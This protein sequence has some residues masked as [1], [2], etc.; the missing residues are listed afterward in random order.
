MRGTLRR[1]A[2]IADKEVRHLQRDP[3]SLALAL[4]MPLVM[5]V[6]FGYGVSFDLDH[7]PLRIVDED[8]SASSRE[9]SRRVF[10]NGEFVG[11]ETPPEGKPFAALV[12]GEVAAV[13]VIHRGF[14][15]ELMR[16]ETPHLQVLI[17]GA[18][19]T[20]A[21][22]L[23]TKVEQTLGFLVGSMRTPPGMVR[24]PPV[25]A[26]TWTRFNPESRSV[27]YLLPGI[28]AFVLA[29]VAVLLTS[30]TIAREWERGSMA[31]LFA[32]PVRRVDI[33]LGKLLPYI[34]L[35]G[36]AVLLVIAAGMAI[37]DVPFRGS[38]LALFVLS[39]LFLIG[40]LGQGLLIS[41]ITRNQMVATQVATLSS[42]LPALLLSGFMFPIANMPTA[43]R[44]L[45]TIIP[46]R[47]YVEGL[48][49]VLLRGNGLGD[50]A[51]EAF[52]MGVFAVA[53]ISLST[54]RFKRSIA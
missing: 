44:G 21:S 30:L 53:V 52:A 40:M 24:E 15:R 54:L 6:L 33:V 4:V 8:G 34:V 18:D 37:F 11:T 12:S 48:R 41:V 45:T 43:L 22:Q 28:A 26:R 25:E 29:M 16:G 27:V 38:A 13:L 20:T 1:I 32:T 51:G 47:Y 39:L 46:A 49:G 50:V 3:L 5:I 42:M 2:A 10:A 36:I 31:Q 19:A 7:L 35:G 17:D 23:R 14:E 9:L